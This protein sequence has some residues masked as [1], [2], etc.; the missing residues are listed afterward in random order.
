MNK[1]LGKLVA[2]GLAWGVWAIAMGL[3]GQPYASGAAV[4]VALKFLSFG[5]GESWGVFTLIAIALVA[6]SCT[7]YLLR[8]L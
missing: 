6:D 1:V 8:G 2:L 7:V 3:S 5:F 4:S